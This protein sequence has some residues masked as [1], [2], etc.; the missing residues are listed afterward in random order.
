[1]V[2]H[3]ANRFARSIGRRLLRQSNYVM[4]AL[5]RGGQKGTRTHTPTH[6]RIHTLAGTH[7]H[8][9]AHKERRRL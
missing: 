8:T 9:Y 1:M 5:A 2:S 6:P 3:T 4:L 7:A